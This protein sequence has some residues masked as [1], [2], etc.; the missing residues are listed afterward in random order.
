MPLVTDFRRFLD[1]CKVQC[2]F[3][4]TWKLVSQ[5]YSI[6]YSMDKVL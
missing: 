2:H 5:V 3:E 1:F 4:P 6:G